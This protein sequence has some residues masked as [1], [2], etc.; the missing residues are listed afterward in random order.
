MSA[1]PTALATM[2]TA[3]VFRS[4]TG[5][6]RVNICPNYTTCLIEI[7]IGKFIAGFIRKIWKL[8]YLEEE[9]TDLQDSSS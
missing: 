9:I 2:L 7:F 8:L 4:S 1:C 5:S 6:S 3:T